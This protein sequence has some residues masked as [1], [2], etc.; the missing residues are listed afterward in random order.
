MGERAFGGGKC[1]RL[2][3]S[4]L[5]AVV[6]SG[7]EPAVAVSQHPALIHAHDAL[8]LGPRTFLDIHRLRLDRGILLAAG[9]AALGG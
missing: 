8:A 2:L 3:R 9:R 6:R 5:E 1:V 4:K 7:M